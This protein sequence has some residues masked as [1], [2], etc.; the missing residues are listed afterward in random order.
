[1]CPNGPAGLGS[2][3]DRPAVPRDRP[4]ARQ[5]CRLQPPAPPSQSVT[6]RRLPRPTALRPPRPTAPG[7]ARRSRRTPP[8]RPRRGPAPRRRGV[9]DPRIAPAPS[10]TRS[11]TG[12]RSSLC[13]N[14]NPVAT[15][16]F[17]GPGRHPQSHASAL[18]GQAPRTFASPRHPHLPQE[19]GTDRARDRRTV[20]HQRR[21]DSDRPE[22]V[23][24]VRG[25]VERV[26]APSRPRRR[27]RRASSPCTAT[28]APSAARSPTIAR[29]AA[30]SASVTQSPATSLART[31]ATPS[32][33]AARM[34]AAPRSAA[35]RRHRDLT[36]Q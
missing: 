7:R 32:S 8:P 5:G 26:D 14:G 29:S 19:R 1:M 10:R 11:D 35:L 34:T 15:T 27:R 4:G 31:A 13:R 23:R 3:G 16:A 28:P 20:S 17:A 25:S 36:G 24:E 18:S 6:T 30:R 2:A 33:P 21:R 12:Q 9:E 22:P